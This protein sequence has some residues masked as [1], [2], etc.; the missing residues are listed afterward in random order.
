MVGAANEGLVL[1]AG[2]SAVFDLV[3]PLLQLQGLSRP[4]QVCCVPGLLR[5]ARPRQLPALPRFCCASAGPGRL[6]ALRPALTVWALVQSVP[7]PVWRCSMPGGAMSSYDIDHHRCPCSV[8]PPGSASG[9]AVPSDYF[10]RGAERPARAPALR[11]ASAPAAWPQVGE[12]VM[13]GISHP[14]P[15]LINGAGYPVVDAHSCVSSAIPTSVFTIS[16]EGCRMRI[17]MG[18]QAQTAAIAFIL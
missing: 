6:R 7:S 5:Y 8:P 11:P 2:G 16:R 15:R 4:V 17:G 10:Y 1:T 13:L 9:T 12:R 18:W 3:L 14:A